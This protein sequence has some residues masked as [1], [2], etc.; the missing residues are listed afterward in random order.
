M[1]DQK[2]AAVDPFAAWRDWLD[3]TERQ[4]NSYF[5]QV[6][7]TEQYARFLGQFNELSLNMQ[8]SMGEAM[9]RYFASLNLPTRDDLTAL[10]QRLNAVEQRLAAIERNNPSSLTD[11]RVVSASTGSRPPRTRKPASTGGKES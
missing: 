6:M 1:A 11:Q 2:T 3:Q 5:N 8:K 7:G 9:G 4:L 10:G